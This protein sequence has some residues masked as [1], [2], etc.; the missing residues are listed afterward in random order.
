LYMMLQFNRKN[1]SQKTYNSFV[2]KISCKNYTLPQNIVYLDFRIS[3]FTI[4]T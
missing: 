1:K 2:C 3:N 4:S